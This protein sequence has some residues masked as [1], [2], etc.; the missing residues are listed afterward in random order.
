MKRSTLAWVYGLSFAL[1]ATLGSAV[2]SIE[3]TPAPQPI[4]VRVIE[5]PEPKVEP[6]PPEPEAPP[7]E[8]PPIVEA[9]KPTRAKP[10]AAPPAEA[11]AP[12]PVAAVPSFGV[13]MSGGVGMGGT[14]VPVGDAHAP[15]EAPTRRVAESRTLN[16][17]PAASTVESDGCAEAAS[18]PRPL[19]VPRPEYTAEA[20]AAGIQ[21]KVRVEITVDENGVVTDVRVIE[22]LDPG[23]DAAALTA[24]RGASFEAATRCGKAVSSTF[25]LAIKFAL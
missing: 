12:A 21:G 3:P 18:K 15:R 24:L 6:P 14:A 8:P 16:A 11:A 5:A 22:S 13:A 20:R 17:P 4:K 1:H 2:A 25:N 7:P 9:P 10:Q 23:L 19:N